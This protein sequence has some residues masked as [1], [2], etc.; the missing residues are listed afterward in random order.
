M[1]EV[2]SQEP[3]LEG[4]FWL[5]DWN[6]Q[7]SQNRIS[8]DGQTVQLE[9][10]VMQVL[11]T[12]ARRPGQTVTK[13]QF[14]EEV[15]GDTV[16]TND[17]LSRCISELR[18]VLGDDARDPRYIETIRKTGYRLIASVSHTRV[19]PESEGSNT[20]NEDPDTSEALVPV[21]A[22]T[23]SRSQSDAATLRRLQLIWYRLRHRM[24]RVPLW[25]LAAVIALGVAG[26]VVGAEQLLTV[27]ARAPAQTVPFTSFPGEESDPALSPEGDQVAFVWDGSDGEGVDIYVKQFDNNTPLRITEHPGVES[28]PAWSPGG[29]RLAFVR[30]D[31]GEYKVVIAPA[32]GG[33]ERTVA[34][35]GEREVR[36]L[37]WSPD[38]EKL[39]LAAQRAPYE[40]FS[41]YLL[42]TE[43]LQ[44]RRLTDPPGYYHG[45][46]NPAFSPDS[47]TLAFTRSMVERIEDVYR[48]KIDGGT[49][50]RL[51]RDRAEVTGL[52]WSADGRNIV[53]ASDRNG[54]FQLWRISA[55][56]GTPE[57]IATSGGDGVHQPSIARQGGRMTMTQRSENTNIW[58]LRRLQG[59]GRFTSH[60]QILSTRW[61]SNPDV[62]PDGE[63]VAFSSKRS[64]HFEIWVSRRDGTESMQLTN[65]SGPFT[66]MPRWSPDGER[67]AFVSRQGENTDVY[68]IDIAGGTPQR[69]TGETADDVAPSWSRDGRWIY[70][71]SDRSGQWQ[72]WRMPVR[73]G[74][75]EQVTERGG[76][77]AFESHDGQA[78]YY[79]KKNTPGIWK[80]PLSGSEETRVL[81]GLD[82]YDWGNWAVTERGLYYVHRDNEQP[83]LSFYSFGSER[84]FRVAHLD[85][86]PRHPSLAVASEGEWFLYAKVDQSESDILLVEN[87]N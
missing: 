49:P 14:M 48:V 1:S 50:K 5:E 11:V 4:G 47:K 51:T 43:T 71:A 85:K 72:I 69:L 52:D 33:S 61:D 60:A 6:V 7:P 31:E 32:I 66:G 73:G 29:D 13:E 40:A 21:A 10:K 75:P 20:P 42:S 78:L 44:Q 39:A 79:V 30:S 76:F 15:W 35:F 65:F 34:D 82:P 26:S 3:S 58:T 53:F 84:H 67:V 74:A 81:D 62:A 46:L 56:G 24:R 64:G 23:A 28:S 12:L 38:G 77:M 55:T 80:R 25:V 45:D 8:K 2:A 54:P 59:Y 68:V 9:P 27:E 16:V 57:W 17:V 19:A 70:F 63:H 86:M 36:G 87:F 41:I 18:K 22:G 37:V 83:V